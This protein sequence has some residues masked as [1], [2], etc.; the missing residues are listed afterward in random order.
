[1]SLSSLSTEFDTKIAKCLTDSP[2]DF[3]SFYKISKGYRAVA[4]PILYETI[5]I[6]HS[7]EVTL[8][9]F[10]LSLIHHPDLALHIK[11]LSILDD[12]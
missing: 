7:D 10:L 12:G 11:S 5:R 1:M 4:D 2:H 8:R 6:G 3:N 9:L